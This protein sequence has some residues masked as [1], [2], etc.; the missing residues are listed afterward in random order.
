MFNYQLIYAVGT[1]KVAEL[2]EHA[3][4][5]AALA[6]TAEERRSQQH[7]PLIETLRLLAS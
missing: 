2:H 3:K 4:R 6:E 7:A 5:H 1:R